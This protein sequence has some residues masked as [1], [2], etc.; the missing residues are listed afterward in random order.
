M[1]LKQAA[2]RLGVHYQTAYKLVRSGALT[3]VR[4]GGTYDISEA[5][6]ERYVSQQEAMRRGVPAAHSA[7]QVDSA[8]TREHLLH[9][10]AEAARTGTLSPRG[11]YA[12]VAH[13]L[14]SVLRDSCIVWMVHHDRHVVEP[15]AHDH[16]VA[17]R[18]S[19]L[20]AY[21]E[22]V[23]FDLDEGFVSHVLTSG[24]R[25]FAPHV[26]RDVL[27]AGTRAE[28]VH[29]LD[30]LP[31]HSMMLVPIVVAGE[32]TGVIETARDS[33]PTPFDVEDLALLQ[34][35][36]RLVGLAIERS[37]LARAAWKRRDAL[38]DAL[39]SGADPEAHLTDAAGLELVFDHRQRLRVANRA[40][41][42]L[43]DGT[44]PVAQRLLDSGADGDAPPTGERLALGELDFHDDEVVVRVDGGETRRFLVVRGVARSD[45]FALLGTVVV[46][47][48]VAEVEARAPIVEER[49]CR[50]HLDALPATVVPHGARRGTLQNV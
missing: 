2:G 29:H 8:D 27:R 43:L 39:R 16:W 30:E 17:R 7:P 49:A 47:Q 46:A 15:I 19:V 45:S 22:H 31:T 12:T 33:S 18:R 9:D 38:L 10:V 11:T 1:N 25:L 20:A 6:I 4:I 44:E 24:K 35:I 21:L 5:A 32:I 50:H 23:P 13:G 42:E 3:A 41:Q 28:F 36:A 14:A 34:E 37:M 48:P 26:P 40:A